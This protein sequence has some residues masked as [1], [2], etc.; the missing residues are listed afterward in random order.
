[1]T[2]KKN[3]QADFGKQ[4]AALPLQWDKK[5]RLRVLMVT[6][7]DSGRWIMPKGWRMDGHKPWTAAQIEALEEAGAEGFIGSDAIGHYWYNKKLDDG[8]HMRCRVTVY[9]MIVEKLRK[10]W[11]ERHQR[12]RRWFAPKQAAKRVAES[13]LADLLK[14]LTKKPHKIPAIRELLESA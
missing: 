14:D 11:K 4:I 13:D 3:K 2:L 8:S 5:G 6:S 1:M 9:P 12:K 10:T 7:R